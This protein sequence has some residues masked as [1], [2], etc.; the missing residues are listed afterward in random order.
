MQAIKDDASLAEAIRV[1][2]SRNLM[3]TEDLK[4]Q[5]EKAKENLNPGAMIKDGIR[6]TVTAP[7]FKE[8]MIKG[9]VSFA[10][11]LLTKKAIVGSAHGGLRSLLGTL[12]QTG[13]TGL[14]YS[15]AD[16]IK[17][18]GASL[19]SGFLKKIRIS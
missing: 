12:I 8:N 15:N 19:L 9:A 5:W 18:K 10:T 11:G 4:L 6:D 1:L 17:S 13:V 7:D 14:A 3:Q 2:E 16:P